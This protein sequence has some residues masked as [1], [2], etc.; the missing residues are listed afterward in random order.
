MK[1]HPTRILLE[2]ADRGDRKVATTRLVRVLV[3]V[4]LVFE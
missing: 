3:T 2:W 1:N 4:F